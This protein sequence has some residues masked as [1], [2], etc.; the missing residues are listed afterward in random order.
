MK[1]PLFIKNAAILTVSSLLLRLFGMAF[2]IWVASLVGS[3]GMGLYQLVLSVFWLFSAFA[4]S[5]LSV[6]ATRLCA[7]NLSLKK[8]LRGV[9]KKCFFLTAAVSLTSGGVMF[10]SSDVLARF[11]VGNESVAL[12]FKIIAFSL[13]AIGVSSC[14]KGYFFAVRKALPSAVSQILEQSARIALS[15]FLVSKT[16]KYGAAAACAALSAGDAVSEFIC[17]AFLYGRYKKDLS[18]RKG[19]QKCGCSFKS[20]HRI[21]FPLTLGRYLSL[22]LRTAENILVPKML[23]KAGSGIKSGLSTFGAVKAMALPVLLFPSGILSAVSSL[24]VPE[25]SAACAKNQ[26]L[27]VRSVTERIMRFTVPVSIVCACVFA[28]CGNDIGMLFYKNGEVGFLLTVLAP[29]VPLMYADSVCDGIL[30][31]LDCQR[32][33]FFVGVS[34]SLIRV[35]AVLLFLPRYGIKAFI[36]IMYF[37]NV[38]TAFLNTGKLIRKTGVQSDPAKSVLLPLCVSLL[39]AKG[40][41]MLFSAFSLPLPL[42]TAAVCLLSFALSFL[43]LG[44][45][46]RT[47]LAM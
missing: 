45:E 31:G 30:K 37:S 44:R 12:C 46:I 32:F 19:L 15:F 43:F 41:E 23:S 16:V 47:V 7:D 36:L 27:V 34:D 13:P 1:K 35:L 33:C 10:L 4:G 22:F 24:L 8:D 2:K 40:A 6:A 5:G 29:I 11:A 3:E 38:Y 20:V 17:C 14:I 25:I 39:S 21:A 26:R 28:V 42:H 18:C 9:M